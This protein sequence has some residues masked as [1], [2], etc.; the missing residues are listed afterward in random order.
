MA[1]V[2]KWEQLRALD[3]YLTGPGA[4]RPREPSFPGFSVLDGYLIGSPMEPRFRSC[5]NRS[6]A[7]ESSGSPFVAGHARVFARPLLNAAFPHDPSRAKPRDSN[8]F[9]LLGVFAGCLLERR[10]SKRRALAVPRNLDA[11]A[12][13]PKRR[14]GGKALQVQWDSPCLKRRESRRF[15]QQVRHHR[16]SASP[17]P[18]SLGV[19]DGYL[20]AGPLSGATP[21]DSSCFPGFGVLDGYLMA[22]LPGELR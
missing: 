7:F 14:I 8:R 22:G 4:E 3:G 6:G 5:R 20:M 11:T 15:R 18:G 10:L 19:L 12:V 9:P 16:V 1:P 17:A 13:A 21:H 2:R